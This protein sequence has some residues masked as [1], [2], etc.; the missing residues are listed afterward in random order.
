LVIM[1]NPSLPLRAVPHGGGE[2]R[3]SAARWLA[4]CALVL[5]ALAAA[6]SAAAD[7]P[8]DTKDK[9]KPS[10]FAPHHGNKSHVYGAPVGKPLLHKQKKR[11]RPAPATAP[12]EPIK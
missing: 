1:M 11:P 3:P 12:A 6:A 10:S 8:S 2:R 4:A 7:P 9:P 5:A